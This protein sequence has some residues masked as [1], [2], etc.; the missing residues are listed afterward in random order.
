[1]Q[2]EYDL[3]IIG[4]GLA[5]LTCAIHLGPHCHVLLLEKNIYP[6]HKVC[7]EYVSNEI[8]PYLHQLEI[9]PD[10]LHAKKITRF[11]MS[12]HSGNV[13]QADLPL[14][15]FGISRYALDE[16]LYNKARDSTQVHFDTVTNVIPD[17]DLYR[18]ETL[19]KR[20]FTSPCI[21]GAYGKRTAIDKVLNRNFIQKKSS[22]LAVKAHYDYSF[23]DSKV[24]LH[25]FEGGYC[26]LSKVETGAV[27][28]CYLTTYKAFKKSNGISDFQKTILSKNPHLNHFFRHAKPIFKEPL[29]I[30]QISFEKK[31]AVHHHIFM[32]GDS[33]GLIHPL[34]GNG[35]AMAIHSAKIFSETFLQYLKGNINR[36]SLEATYTNA[37]RDAFS[38]RLKTG[39]YIQQLLL[40]PYLAKTSYTIAQTFPGIVPRVI[41]K[42][43]GRVVI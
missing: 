30:S 28:A 3:I 11:E 20:S 14:G 7:G 37:W 36:E 42:T 6:H 2:K 35:M 24:A 40:H 18:V 5:G 19:Q 16:A 33:A 39:K 9:F 27:N 15:G 8:T 17:G 4:G 22:W 32:V 31:A 43:H 26:G 21:V 25:T 12:T 34:C 1:M 29:A 13:L 10:R 23:N 41:K 38:K